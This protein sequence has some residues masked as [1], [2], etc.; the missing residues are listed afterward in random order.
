VCL[1]INI[2]HIYVSEFIQVNAF[3]FIFIGAKRLV[4]LGLGDDD[5]CIEDDFSAWFV[6]SLPN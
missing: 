5:Q 3:L 1:I 4:P 6:A 2:M